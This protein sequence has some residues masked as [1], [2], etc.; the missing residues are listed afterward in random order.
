[1]ALQV[2]WQL[3]LLLLL[4]ARPC[5]SQSSATT[6]GDPQI[7]GKFDFY[8]QPL[9]AKEYGFI[10][11]KCYSGLLFSTCRPTLPSDDFTKNENMPYYNKLADMYGVQ[12]CAQCCGTTS[13]N[14]DVWDMRCDLDVATAV[15]SNVY[16]YELRLA[17]HQNPSA[18]GDTSIVTCPL[19]RSACQYSADGK[20]TLN[21]DGQATDNTY[22]VGYTLTLTI[23]QYD[24][25]FFYWRG[26]ADC[27]IVSV[28]SLTPPQA[29]D[30]FHEEIV[31]VH[32]PNIAYSR[33]DAGKILLSLLAVYFF[34]YVTLYYFRRKKCVFCQGKLVFS[35]E[36]CYKCKFVGAKPPDPFLMQALEEKGEHMQGE[37]PD[38][39]PG[40]RAFVRRVVALWEGLLVTLRTFGIIGNSAAAVHPRPDGADSELDQQQHGTAKGGGG[41]RFKYPSWLKWFKKWRKRRLQ[42]LEE[43]KFNPS[44]LAQPQYVIFAAVGHHDPPPPDEAAIA[45]RKDQ[46]TEA[47]GFNPEDYMDEDGEAGGESKSMGGAA[48]GSAGG[49]GPSSAPVPEW[50]KKYQ[51][52]LAPG[53]ADVPTVSLWMRWKLRR[54]F[55]K[56]RNKSMPIAW[57]FVWPFACAIIGLIIVLAVGAAI[58]TGAVSF[59][60]PTAVPNTPKAQAPPV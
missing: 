32:I 44:I 52:R 42:R 38:R 45:A 28:E 29:G 50:Q 51:K 6:T 19:K 8:F 1:M 59:S 25:N 48:E 33:P 5:A 14:I 34:A 30:T 21:C 46:I 40:S 58:I 31:F 12:Y 22:L 54:G 49:K 3:L 26:V 16:G 37:L 13:N 23:Q 4:Q 55:V 36:M 43:K 56:Q 7:Y 39:L 35:K 9:T 20:T 17:S 11:T 10:T 15:T 18:K 41:G 24:Q 27:S 53:V 60:D 47:L 2:L 57:R